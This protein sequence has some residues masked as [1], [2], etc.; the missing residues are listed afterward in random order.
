MNKKLGTAFLYLLIALLIFWQKDFLLAWVEIADPNWAPLVAVAATLFSLFPVIPYPLV[1]AVIG[2]AY[3]PQLGGVIVW[4]GSSMASVLMFLFIRYVFKDLGAK[5]L[6]AKHIESFT[7]LF[8][9]NAFFAILITRMI[10]VIPS[11][12]INTYAGLSRV[13]FW[14][15]TI[16]STIGKIPAMLL[17]ALIGD[18][19]MRSP[20]HLIYSLLFYIAFLALVYGIYKLWEKGVKKTTFG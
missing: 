14:I 13:S 4:F 2:A 1:G 19:A 20:Q 3:G 11:I 8:E 10:P 5:W 6:Y 17:F 12:I 9:R 7:L 16:A 18:Q 15:Y